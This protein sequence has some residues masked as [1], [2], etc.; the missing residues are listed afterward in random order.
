M[1]NNRETEGEEAYVVDEVS[2]VVEMRTVDIEN[3]LGPLEGASGRRIP[4]LEV[5]QSPPVAAR[6]GPG[7][8]YT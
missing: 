6:S 7:E 5:A 2:E 4:C 8:W 1:L 3:I